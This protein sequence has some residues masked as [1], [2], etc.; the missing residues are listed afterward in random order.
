MIPNSLK[1][2]RKQETPKQEEPKQKTTGTC[3]PY[4]TETASERRSTN[5]SNSRS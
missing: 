5:L 3:P 1:K 4:P 2:E